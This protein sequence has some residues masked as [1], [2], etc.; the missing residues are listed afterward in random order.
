LIVEE[1]VLISISLMDPVPEPT[2]LLMPET[3][4][5]VQV[6]VVPGMLVGV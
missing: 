1:V 5:L 6:K 2:V 4:A 3:A